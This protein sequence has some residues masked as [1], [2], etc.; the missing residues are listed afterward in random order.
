MEMPAQIVAGKWF[1]KKTPAALLHSSLPGV[2]FWDTEAR[3]PLFDGILG[4]LFPVRKPSCFG[5]P[6]P[7]SA[8]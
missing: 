1:S 3:K 8:K 4:L 5:T 2:P 6:G 7:C